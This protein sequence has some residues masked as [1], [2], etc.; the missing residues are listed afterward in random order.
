M[1]QWWERHDQNE[2]AHA[3]RLGTVGGSGCGR[4]HFS[5]RAIYLLLLKG[6]QIRGKSGRNKCTSA[7]AIDI[8]IRVENVEIPFL[9]MRRGVVMD[10]AGFLP[11][12][13]SNNLLDLL[14]VLYPNRMLPF[15]SSTQV[16]ACQFGFRKRQNLPQEQ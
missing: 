14:L 11:L 6:P 3:L 4:P 5:P 10:R 1:Y 8:A 13:H 16:N 12:H 7:N 2:P 9:S 15:G